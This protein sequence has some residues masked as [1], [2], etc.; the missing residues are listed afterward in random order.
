VERIIKAAGLIILMIGVLLTV[1]S[2]IAL[3]MIVLKATLRALDMSIFDRALATLA[4][5]SAIAIIAAI[6]GI[7]IG[8]LFIWI[9]E[10]LIE[11][12]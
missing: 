9:G 12:K 7:A 2:L 5:T 11:G 3:P 8:L 6:I 1:V 4:L 10:K